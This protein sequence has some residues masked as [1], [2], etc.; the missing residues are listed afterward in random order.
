M[1]R[2]SKSLQCWDSLDHSNVETVQ[3]T[4]MLAR[5]LKRFLDSRGDLSFRHQ[6]RLSF[7]IDEENRCCHIGFNTLYLMHTT[8]VSMSL[9]LLPFSSVAISCLRYPDNL[10]LL[11]A[12]STWDLKS[13]HSSKSTSGISFTSLANQVLFWIAVNVVVV[14]SLSQQQHYLTKFF[15]GN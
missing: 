4:A 9:W 1:L 10:S 15:F 3:I 7:I 11:T 12:Q 5:I 2:Q 13:V 8:T 6:W 14:V